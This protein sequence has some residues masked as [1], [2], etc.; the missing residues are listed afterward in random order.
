MLQFF[1]TISILT[2]L[3]V[4]DISPIL[5]SALRLGVGRSR[6]FLAIVHVEMTTFNIREHHNGKTLRLNEFG[7]PVGGSPPRRDES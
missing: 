5:L 1:I 2:M 3:L 7:G 6:L 4:P